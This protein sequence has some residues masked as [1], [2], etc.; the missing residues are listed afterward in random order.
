MLCGCA[1]CGVGFGAGI[2]GIAS[3]AFLG[4]VLQFAQFLNSVFYWFKWCQALLRS[5]SPSS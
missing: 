1:G 4:I 3:S 2:A 5:T